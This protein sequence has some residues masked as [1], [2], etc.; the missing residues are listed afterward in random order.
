[1]GYTIKVQL[2]KDATIEVSGDDIPTV[3]KLLNAVTKKFYGN[4]PAAKIEIWDIR[5]NVY[6][7]LFY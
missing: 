6:Y 2:M 7:C 5:K 3:V 4:T 1:M